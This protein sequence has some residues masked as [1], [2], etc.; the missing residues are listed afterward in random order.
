MGRLHRHAGTTGRRLP[1]AYRLEPGNVLV[2]GRAYL[3]D[4]AWPTRG[5]A[6]ID[7]ACLA[8]WLIASGHSPYSAESCAARVPSWQSA[9]ADALDEFARVQALM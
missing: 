2:N 4:W 6:W 1:P 9:P 3:V 5:A 8:V 7:P